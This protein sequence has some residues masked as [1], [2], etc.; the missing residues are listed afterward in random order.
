M[1]NV[2]C[3]EMAL[4]LLLCNYVLVL[5]KS[6]YYKMYSFQNII[7]VIGYKTKKDIG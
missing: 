7:V 1:L 4:T 6:M 3:C 2:V 5:V